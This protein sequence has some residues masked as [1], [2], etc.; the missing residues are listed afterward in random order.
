MAW[1]RVR[2]F[3]RRNLIL[4]L[5]ASL[6]CTSAMLYVVLINFAP[7]LAELGPNYPAPRYLF[8][9]WHVV[10]LSII[11]VYWGGVTHFVLVRFERRRLHHYTL[12]F[13]LFAA[14]HALTAL[15][16]LSGTVLF[17]Y[18]YDPSSPDIPPRP[19][20]PPLWAIVL[21]LFDAP[22]MLKW[23]NGLFVVPAGPIIWW[24]FYRVLARV[25]F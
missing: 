7:F 24:F 19:D 6:G 21:H 16:P 22:L 20:I 9:A 10:L 13:A 15:I 12:S 4:R 17:I 11:T 1:E 8:S 14:M 18:G 5:I 2:N 3:A 25:P 23:L